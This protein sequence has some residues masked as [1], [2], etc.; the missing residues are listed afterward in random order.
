MMNMVSSMVMNM[1]MNIMMNTTMLEVVN[2]KPVDLLSAE[3]LIATIVPIHSHWS[4]D[5]YGQ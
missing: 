5:E 1:M 3:D 4:Y 2:M